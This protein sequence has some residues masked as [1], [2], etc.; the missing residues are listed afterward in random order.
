MGLILYP[1]GSAMLRVDQF[2]QLNLKVAIPG[3]GINPMP[4]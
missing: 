1:K 2:I 4:V 3:F